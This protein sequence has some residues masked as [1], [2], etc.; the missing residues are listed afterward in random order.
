V[1]TKEEQRKV[2]L[3]NLEELYEW[4]QRKAGV[5]SWTPVDELWSRVKNA[6]EIKSVFSQKRRD[7]T[8]GRCCYDFTEADKQNVNT[9][10]KR[11]A[12]QGYIKFS[13]SGKAFKVLKY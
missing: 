7:D 11:L 1:R 5:F 2:I 9:V 10:I 3:E 6:M 8:N 4:Q 13:K 12:E